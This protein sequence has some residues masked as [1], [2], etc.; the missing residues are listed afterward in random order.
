MILK[1]STATKLYQNNHLA[2]D[3]HIT[4][5]PN[6]QFHRVNICKLTQLSWGPQHHH[7]EHVPVSVEALLTAVEGVVGPASPSSCSSCSTGCSGMGTGSPSR[8]C[9]VDKSIPSD[10]GLLRTVPSSSAEMAK[11]GISRSPEQRRRT[12]K[13]GLESLSVCEDSDIDKRLRNLRE[14]TRQSPSVELGG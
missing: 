3:M 9:T 8:D 13:G 1:T 7:T 4:Q 5:H 11:R 2:R 6:P 12:V 14:K 10:C